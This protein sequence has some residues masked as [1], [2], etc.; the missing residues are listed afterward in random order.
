M[1][2]Q[3]ITE[4]VIEAAKEAGKFALKE[5]ANFLQHKVEVKGEHNFVSYVDKTCEKMLVDALSKTV[6]LKSHGSPDD[7][8]EAVVYLC[9]SNF[10]TGVV[11]QVDGGLHLMEYRD[12]PHSH[13]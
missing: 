9:R 1:I 8:A 11:I 7:I 6:P 10:L 5:R 4:Q 2:L 3:I 12:G 13:P